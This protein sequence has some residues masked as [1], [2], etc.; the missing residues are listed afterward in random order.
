MRAD[1]QVHRNSAPSGLSVH[2]AGQYPC[3]SWWAGEGGD[4]APPAGADDPFSAYQRGY[5]ATA[6]KEATRKAEEQKDPNAMALA[7]AEAEGL[8]AHA[9]S[10]AI[11]L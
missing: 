7:L 6:F 9:R 1:P 8:P 4:P 11:R 3:G 10:V 5:Y 2:R